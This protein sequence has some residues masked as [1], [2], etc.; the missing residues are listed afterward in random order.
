MFKGVPAKP[1]AYS[2]GLLSVNDGLLWGIVACYFGLLWLLYGLLWG[3]VAYYFRL[4]GVPGRSLTFFLVAFR[5]TLRAEPPA[6]S[7]C[8]L[9]GSCRTDPV[10]AAWRSG[11]LFA[12]AQR[13]KLFCYLRLP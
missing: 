10:R 13:S 2:Y 4:L 6:L 7:G 8:H 5:L 12:S 9:R 3:I 1:A 11:L